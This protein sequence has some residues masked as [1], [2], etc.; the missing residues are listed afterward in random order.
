MARK[1]IRP[2]FQAPAQR[3]KFWVAACVGFSL[4]VSAQRSAAQS[5][6]CSQPTIDRLEAESDNIRDWSKLRAFYRRYRACRVD[7]AEVTEGV[8]ES[9]ARMLADHWDTLPAASIL[10]KQDPPFEAFALAGINIT[11]STDDLNHIDKLAAEHCPADLHVLCRKIRQSI[12][13]NN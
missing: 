12:R 3:M 11:D 10:F 1:R 8:S 7:D 13:D 2:T 6:R 9:V 5:G 4:C